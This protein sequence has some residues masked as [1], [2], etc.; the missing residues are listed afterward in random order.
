ML[1]VICF[2]SCASAHQLGSHLPAF[3]YGNPPKSFPSCYRVRFPHDGCGVTMNYTPVSSIN[4][5]TP[6]HPRMPRSLHRTVQSFRTPVQLLRGP[7]LVAFL[8]LSRIPSELA[9]DTIHPVLGASTLLHNIGKG[10][11]RCRNCNIV[12]RTQFDPRGIRLESSL[13]CKRDRLTALCH[14]S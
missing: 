12:A 7:L 5:L 2:G 3:E 13:A 10:V 1:E 6:S 8:S 14:Q 11:S 4:E 9:R